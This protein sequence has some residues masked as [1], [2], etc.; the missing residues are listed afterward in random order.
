MP[1]ITPPPDDFLCNVPL[2]H[3]S[4]EFYKKIYIISTRLP[5]KDKLGIFLRI[6]NYCLRVIELLL[7]TALTA[8]INKITH[9]EQLRIHLEIIKRLFRI[10]YELSIISQKQFI[11][12]ISILQ[13]M[14]KM[15]NGWIKSLR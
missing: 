5:K 11:E 9:L 2:V 4:F 3:I 6:E 10:S 13:E 14:S 15:T 7:E 12:L 1:S 8:K